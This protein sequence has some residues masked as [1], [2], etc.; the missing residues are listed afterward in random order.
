MFFLWHETLAVAI[1]PQ[2]R[3][4][5]NEQKALGEAV[6][7]IYFA[8]NSDYE[9]ALWKIV[10]LLGGKEAVAL[11]ESDEDVAYAKYSKERDGN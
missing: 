2:S 7:V 1:F 6:A 5:T 8:D 4:M 11:L 3:F 10:E 9:S